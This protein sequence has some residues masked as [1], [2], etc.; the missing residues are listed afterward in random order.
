MKTLLFGFLIL[1]LCLAVSSDNI[2]EDTSTVKE[3]IEKIRK[4]RG[5][6]EYLEETKNEAEYDKKETKDEL[7]LPKM[8]IRIPVT[9][10]K[11]C[12]GGHCQ[13]EQYDI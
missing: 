4:S 5:M 7:S 8:K 6:T 1:V 12:K 13:E 10:E 11:S 3:A 2:E 9:S